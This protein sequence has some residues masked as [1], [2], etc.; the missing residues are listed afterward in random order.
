MQTFL[1]GSYEIKS[2]GLCVIFLKRL[3][4]TIQRFLITQQTICRENPIWLRNYW[5]CLSAFSSIVFEITPRIGVP[6]Y[7]LRVYILV[8]ERAIYLKY[9][10]RIKNNR[11]TIG[12]P[13]ER[14]R[15]VKLDFEFGRKLIFEN[16]FYHVLPRF[17]FETRRGR[18]RTWG[19][20]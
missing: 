12:E 7:V 20:T 9:L 14:C 17:P 10:M 19:K 3:H 18:E 2:K 8:V 15:V 16:S 1:Y 5:R 11:K 6:L 4:R 13:N